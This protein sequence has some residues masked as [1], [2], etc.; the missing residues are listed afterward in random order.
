MGAVRE[1]YKRL[2][3]AGFDVLEKMLVQRSRKGC[4]PALGRPDMQ[5]GPR[6]GL[7]VLARETMDGVALGHVR[8]VTR[9][10]IGVLEEAGRSPHV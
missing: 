6:K 4:L 8:S 3:A 9:I 10:E 7:R 1:R 2:P 5:D